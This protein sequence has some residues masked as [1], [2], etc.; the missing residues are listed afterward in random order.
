MKIL[1]SR[2]WGYGSK[3][4]KKE[5][6]APITLLPAGDAWLINSLREGCVMKRLL[7]KIEQLLRKSAKHV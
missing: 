6:K 3:R 7:I 2:Y 1:P 4:E 5:D